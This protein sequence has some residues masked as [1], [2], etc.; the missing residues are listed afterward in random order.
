M[1]VIR[2]AAVLGAG[3]MGTAVA[4][5][6]AN[7][8]IPTLLLDLAPT[9]LTEEEQKKK[10][11]LES[12]AV[13]NRLAEAG[14]AAA[15][16]GRPAAFAHA[17]RVSLLTPGNFDDDLPKLA[18]VDWVIEAVVERLDIKKDLLARVAKHVGPNTIVST[19]SSGLSVNAMAAALPEDLKT[20]FLGTHFFFPPRYMYLLELIPGDEDRPGRRGRAERLRRAPPGQ[21]GGP[22]QRPAQLRGQPRRHVLHAS[23][24]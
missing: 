4:A 12:K 5:H 17:S 23:M 3:R 6:L 21:G 24:P 1:L 13:R 7:A 22:Q 18:D 8:G 9:E 15:A 14:I 2:R 10:L 11:T 16:K 20:R 19:N